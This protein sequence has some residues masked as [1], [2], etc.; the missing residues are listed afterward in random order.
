MPPVDLPG[1]WGAP[2]SP[3]AP[4]QLSREE[5]PPT[6]TPSS[7]GSFCFSQEPVFLGPAFPESGRPSRGCPDPGKAARKKL[8]PG[9]MNK[10]PCK[11][12]NRDANKNGRQRRY[13]R[14]A[15]KGQTEVTDG[16]HRR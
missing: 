16:S 4:G 12:R 3:D 9:R 15:R 8:V 7:S 6:R 14:L 5:L 11:A 1:T 2:A 10:L 13:L